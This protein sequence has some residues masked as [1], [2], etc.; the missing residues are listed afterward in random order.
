MDSIQTVIHDYE[1][2][3]FYVSLDYH[4]DDSELYSCGEWGNLYTELGLYDN[5]PTILDGDTDLDE[6]GLPDNHLWNSFAG[7][8][9]S[10]YAFID[11]HMVIRYLSYMPDFD[12][13][14]LNLIP[15]LVTAMYGCT[16]SEASNYDPS[17]VYN[18][19]SCSEMD[20]HNPSFIP[21]K[22]DILS[23]YP[24]PFNPSTTIEYVL[25]EYGQFRI[26]VFD[27]NGNWIADPEFGKKPAGKYEV[28]WS[29]NHLP[30][31][32]YFVH[33]NTVTSFE[34]RKLMLIK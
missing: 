28:E 20:I 21:E 30:G 10:A 2:V 22:I 8:T 17:A 9:Y 15:E 6:D 16:D 4:T 14:T 19:G 1:E 27:I 24:N 12:L 3:E 31:G 11:H 26:S 7:E 18:N 32:V 23:A 25:T 5:Q 34:T 13:F 33:L 29:A